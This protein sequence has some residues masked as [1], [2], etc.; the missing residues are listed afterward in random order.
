M[1]RYESYFPP[2]A[3]SAGYYPNIPKR[4]GKHKR[5][6]YG[7]AGNSQPTQLPYNYRYQASSQAF[8]PFPVLPGIVQAP[9]YENGNPYALHYV[10]D[11]MQPFFDQGTQYTFQPLPQQLPQ[12]LS[13]QGAPP[14]NVT[15]QS[16]P[17][18][19][20][21][22]PYYYTT[23]IPQQSSFNYSFQQPAQYP[24]EYS[25]P[26][27]SYNQHA[28]QFSSNAGVPYIP[29]D[30][31]PIPSAPPDQNLEEAEYQEQLPL[32]SESQITYREDNKDYSRKKNMLNPYQP[33]EKLS[34]GVQ[35]TALAYRTSPQ[36]Y[37]PYNVADYQKVRQLDQMMTLPHS[38]GP[39]KSSPEYLSKV[40][41]K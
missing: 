23:T 2:L 27:V 39:S 14:P 28:S 8:N 16:L 31:H 19:Q 11:Q 21:M 41:N 38:L 36:S 29:H 6:Y 24:Q 13:F 22:I 9:G 30:L 1:A 35:G 18:Q 4:S 34:S 15:Y 7:S 25:H 20:T 37:Q 26:P 17:S 32:T 33:K 10:N 12:S 5:T 3:T 40:R